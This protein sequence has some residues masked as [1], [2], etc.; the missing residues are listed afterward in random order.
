MKK[1][2]LVVSFLLFWFLSVQ[3]SLAEVN[4]DISQIGGS[5]TSPSSLRLTNIKVPGWGGTYWADFQ[6]DPVNC[7][8]YVTNYG[9]ESIPTIKTWVVNYGDLSGGNMA[10]TITTYP[11]N[12][13]VNLSFYNNGLN[14]VYVCYLG[15]IF[16]QGI[17]QFDVNDD[18]YFIDADTALFIPSG[19]DGCMDLFPGVIKTA[20]VSNVPSWFDY[21][22]PFTFSY[23]GTMFNLE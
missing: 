4:I 10:I 20:V 12:R 3:F 13:T 15:I 22:Q 18:S 14:G 2:G 11:E 17:N 1:I 8:F 7:V 5:I 19:W 9:L 21:S 6:W 16:I 23:Y